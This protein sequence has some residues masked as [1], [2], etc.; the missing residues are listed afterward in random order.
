MLP[1]Y[2]IVCIHCDIS[3]THICRDIS[4]A[5]IVERQG[6][7]F[8]LDYHLATSP[9]DFQLDHSGITGQQ[10]YRALSLDAAN[11][12]AR[13]SVATDL[14]SLF[15]SIL[16]L[17]SDG[18][19][20]TWRHISSPKPIHAD[21]WR[22]MT[23]ATVWSNEVLA[24][25]KPEIQ[26]QIERLHKLFSFDSDYFSFLKTSVTVEAFIAACESGV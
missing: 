8:L 23:R 2:N 1:I 20:L 5:S 12:N 10:V 25:C 24:H 18:K 13:H 7:G 22:S 9:D 6:E 17:A 16:D 4:P 3:C 14:E 19:A 11:D 21:K 15:Y 26:P